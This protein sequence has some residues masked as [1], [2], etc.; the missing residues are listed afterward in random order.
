MHGDQSESRIFHSYM[1][2]QFRV[3]SPAK[4]E[5]TCPNPKALGM[6]SGNILDASVTASSVYSAS[7][8]PQYGRLRKKRGGCAWLTKTGTDPKKSWLQVDFGKKTIVTGVATQGSCVE[9]QWV[10]SYVIWYIDDAAN[11]KYYNEG[12]AK[13]VGASL[14]LFTTAPI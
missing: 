5:Q 13:K 8:V 12:G 9:N 7:W 10:K 4:G 2:N 1:I 11:W 3:F 14:G 6:E